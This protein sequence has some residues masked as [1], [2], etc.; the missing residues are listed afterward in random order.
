MSKRLLSEVNIDNITYAPVRSCRLRSETRLVQVSNVEVY[1]DMLIADPQLQGNQNLAAA[2]EAFN[3]NADVDAIT[4]L[5]PLIDRRRRDEERDME[6]RR[7]E[8]THLRT[9]TPVIVDLTEEE[10]KVPEVSEAHGVDDEE[11]KAPELIRCNCS[12]PYGKCPL[13]GRTFCDCTCIDCD[14]G[15]TSCQR[16]ALQCRFSR[17]PLALCLCNGCNRPY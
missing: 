9:V 2:L 13:T 8:V 15:F 7:P 10:A 3:H 1:N 12:F 11:A 16:C 4:N 5:A 6:A 14:R 17:L